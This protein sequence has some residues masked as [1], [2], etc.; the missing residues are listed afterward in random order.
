MSKS[1]QSA[2][3]TK[4]KRAYRACIVAYN[5]L[6]INGDIGHCNNFAVSK[7]KYIVDKLM[8]CEDVDQPPIL[9]RVYYNPEN[10][11]ILLGKEYVEEGG[12]IKTTCFYH[13]L[14]R[15]N[16]EF[17]EDMETLRQSMVCQA[18]G[19]CHYHCPNQ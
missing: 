3:E 8:P 15:L 18:Q 6:H 10:C 13:D 17:K 1:P 2:H 19:H 7:M 11:E 14:E 5:H 4:N 9:V 16:P 12:K